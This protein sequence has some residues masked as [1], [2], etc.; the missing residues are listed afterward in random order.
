MPGT[1]QVTRTFRQLRGPGAPLY[2]KRRLSSSAPS[3]RV[4]ASFL[5]DSH[6]L[7]AH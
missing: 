6:C 3:P 1:T 5:C 2:I 4:P 7:G